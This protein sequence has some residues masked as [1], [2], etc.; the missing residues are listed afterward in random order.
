M[1]RASAAISRADSIRQTASTARATQDRQPSRLP[2]LAPG[3]RSA[4]REVLRAEHL[5]TSASPSQLGHRSRCSF[6]N[7]EAHSTASSLDRT[8]YSA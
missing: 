6:M 4:G 2:I 5:Q 7:R 1:I 3:R 8:W